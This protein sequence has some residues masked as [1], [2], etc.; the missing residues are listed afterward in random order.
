MKFSSWILAIVMIIVVI[1]AYFYYNKPGQKGQSGTKESFA[2]NPEDGYHNMLHNV[3]KEMLLREPTDYEATLYKPYQDKEADLKAQLAQTTEYIVRIKPDAA[4]DTFT[5]SSDTTLEAYRQIVEVYNNV[6]ERMPTKY[7]LTFYADKITKN[8]DFTVKKDLVEILQGSTE[9]KM[10]EKMQTNQ[11]NAELPGNIT[12]QQ[13]TLDVRTVYKD[14]Y[15]QDAMPSAQLE[16]FL[17]SKY[18]EYD[19]DKDKLKKL[20]IF[21]QQMDANATTT[22][23][24]TTSPSPTPSTPSTTTTV[25]ATTNSIVAGEIKNPP[26]Q[27]DT[28]SKI[29]NDV[30]GLQGSST[31]LLDQPAVIKNVP[32]T[33]T[34]SGSS[35]SGQTKTTTTDAATT[36]KTSSSSSATLNKCDVKP[37]IQTKCDAYQDILNEKYRKFPYDDEYSILYKANN[38][39]AGLG[40][41]NNMYDFSNERDLY[42][43]LV[44]KRNK[45]DAQFACERSKEFNKVDD[46]ITGVLSG[47]FGTPLSQA[48]ET[49]VGSILPKF[50]YKTL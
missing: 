13:V 46:E 26:S 20:I 21:L 1:S 10:L 3:F 18:I 49:S 47:G 16:P 41:C 27:L 39:N 17:K 28:S 38:G 48:A 37:E 36:G 32:N 43:E 44:A 33:S 30:K 35:A 24:V 19:V 15:G 14:V 42:A 29:V 23:V 7:E 6:L 50:V 40:T 12:D 11:V 34:T 5:S 45:N 8:P 2:T 22:Q 4:L 25:V 31:A 9:Y